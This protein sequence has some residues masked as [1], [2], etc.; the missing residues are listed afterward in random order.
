MA[1]SEPEQVKNCTEASHDTENISVSD[2]DKS[3]EQTGSSLTIPNTVLTPSPLIQSTTFTPFRTPR[4]SYVPVVPSPLLNDI[5]P[6][7]KLRHRS[8]IRKTPM[9]KRLSHAIDIMEEESK[10]NI[11]VPLPQQVEDVADGRP[12]KKAARYIF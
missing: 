8:S 4:R 3:K 1:S 10:E 2:A 9:P 7:P 5:T 6:Q 11:S 12:N